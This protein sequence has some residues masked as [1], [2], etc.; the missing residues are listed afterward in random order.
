MSEPFA[1][2]R[3]RLFESFPMEL[4]IVRGEGQAGVNPYLTYLTGIEER[5]A[6]LVLA[7]EPMRIGT[8]WRYPGPD[9]VRGQQVRQ[10]LFLPEPSA[11]AEVWGEG[12]TAT[13]DSVEASALGVDAILPAS[14]FADTL[15]PILAKSE[16]VG[17]VRGWRPTLA[18]GDDPDTQ[19]ARTLRE[20]F[21]GLEPFDASPAVAEMRRVKASEEIAAMRRA[22]A[23]TAEALR[24][25][26]AKIAP[27]VREAELEGEITRAYREAGATH[28]FDPIVASGRNALKLHY[29][30]NDGLLESGDLLLI[31]TGARIDGYCADVSRT[32]P[33]DGS[34][35]PRQRELYELVHAT[36]RDATERC[37]AGNTLG[38]L[39]AGAWSRSRRRATAVA[40]FTASATTWESKRT[41]SAT[42]RHRSSPAS[43]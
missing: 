17:L 31:D 15:S 24:R 33:V 34:F 8:G 11:F 38:E 1:A 14:R 6:T 22:V 18:G 29:T 2:R 5:G 10:L 32:Y 16:R 39:H 12:A 13:H 20:R 4:C 37:V 27:G 7:A 21:I 19:F 26:V 3:R 28:A 35:T 23:V 41:T 43:S 30:D 25:V 42:S 40:S 36:L 9:Y